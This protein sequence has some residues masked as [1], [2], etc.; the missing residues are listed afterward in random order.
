MRLITFESESGPSLG[1]L[2]ELKR[3]D[4]HFAILPGLTMRSLIEQGERGLDL[5]RRALQ[6]SRQPLS[7]VRLMAPIPEPRRNVFC[8]G[9]NYAEHSR[10][11]A[12][13]RG[14][15]S[16]KEQKL[17]ERP[18]FFTKLG[19]TVNAPEGEIPLDT[20]VTTQLDWEV[21]L[22]VILGRDGKNI[23][24][25]AAMGH[26]FGYTIIND[27]S[28][29]EV[30]VSHGGQFFKGKS[31]DGTCPMGPWIVTADEL[32]PRDLALRCRVNGILKQEGRTSDMIFDISSTLEWLSRGTTLLAGDIIASGT[33]SGVGFARNPPEFLQDGDEVECEIEG[34]GLLR[35]CVRAV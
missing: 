25:E 15:L 9:W 28:A 12:E 24:R 16:P 4:D 26:V 31:L 33:P 10:E 34:I 18:I 27:I 11:A 14:K 1:V 7:S 8:L 35:N 30:Q 5:A 23:S 3:G 22:G 29:R 6:G 2:P 20:R 21:E 32:D 17:P 19:T 13:A